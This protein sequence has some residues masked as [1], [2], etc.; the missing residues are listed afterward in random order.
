VLKITKWNKILIICG[1]VWL[2]LF[3]SSLYYIFYINPPGVISPFIIII[4]FAGMIIAS[5]AGY[6]EHQE[7]KRHDA[8]IANLKAQK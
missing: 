4:W 5:I 3:F 6:H 7:I 8:N 1:V 2:I